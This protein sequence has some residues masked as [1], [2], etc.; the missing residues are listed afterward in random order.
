MEDVDSVGVEPPKRRESPPSS[1]KDV[2]LPEEDAVGR[3]IIV[4]VGVFVQKAGP[5]SSTAGHERHCALRVAS[6]MRSPSSSAR[7]L[8]SLKL[9]DAES[10]LGLECFV[11]S[12]SG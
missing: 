7:R 2:S 9:G 8:K 3:C 1:Q 10:C 5:N 4:A 6:L 12:G 11:E